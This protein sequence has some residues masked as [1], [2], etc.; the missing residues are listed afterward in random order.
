M[1][2][3][4]TTTTTTPSVEA[5]GSRPVEE[6]LAKARLLEAQCERLDTINT[7]LKQLKEEKERLEAELLDRYPVGKQSAGEYTLT[8]N[9]G[10]RSLDPRAFEA[11]YPIAQHPDYYEN[12]PKSMSAIVRKIGEDALAGCVKTLKPTVKV[13]RA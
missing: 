4:T 8:I 13:S 1:S 5:G 10:R 3:T 9:A 12:K 6:H 11:A 7:Q 2:N